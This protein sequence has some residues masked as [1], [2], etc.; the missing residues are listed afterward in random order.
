VLDEAAGRPGCTGG[1]VNTITTTTVTEA[2]PALD[3][4]ARQREVLT[5]LAHEA[6][7]QLPRLTAQ[8]M[9]VIMNR[10]GDY[11]GARGIVLADDLRTVTRANL[12]GML[13]VLSSA[14][15]AGAEDLSVALFTGRRR[16]E[17][18]VPLEAALHAFRLAGRELLSA[19]LACAR[20]RPP[21]ELATFLGIVTVAFD[22]VDTYSQALVEGYRHAESLLDR[23]DSQR[24]EAV[25]DVLL[26]GADAGPTDLAQSAALLGL[27]AQGPY[28]LLLCTVDPIGP[29][30]TSAVRDICAAH[31]LASVWCIRGDTELGIVAL[32]RTTP[33]RLLEQ[34]RPA[35]C[36]RLGLSSVFNSL[37]EVPE[38]HRLAGLALRTVE[39]EG[40]GLAWIEER[41]LEAIVVSSPD[42]SGRLTSRTL[43]G[44]LAL[45]EPDRGLLLETLSAWF[46]CD[47]SAVLAARRLNCHRNT[48][49]NRLRHIEELIG[50]SLDHHSGLIAC[51]IALVVLR[52]LPW[53]AARKPAV[54]DV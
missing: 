36:G 42:L 46:E 14:R 24:R 20:A 1:Q 32:G 41:L 35:V 27:P 5:S 4:D 13:D 51:Y 17:Q 48:V 10:V 52:L 39:P 11:Y 15:C 47:R 26:G 40:K 22:I 30:A 29:T 38:A 49:L 18:G 45:R 54:A 7:R 23:C 16:A 3:L 53:E 37:H 12:V 34:L 21:H 2:T 33:T 25:L 31:H 8:A 9:K 28:A 44:V 6:E 43:G 50:V 19:L